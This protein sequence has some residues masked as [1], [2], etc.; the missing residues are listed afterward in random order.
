MP[1]KCCGGYHE[2][3]RFPLRETKGLFF[4]GPCWI[5]DSSVIL[6]LGSEH[7]VQEFK[8]IPFRNLREVVFRKPQPLQEDGMP[9][10]ALREIAL[11]KEGSGIPWYLA[12]YIISMVC[13]GGFRV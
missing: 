1:G 6:K 4:V 10:T 3:M 11:L 9:G 12:D 13:I 8:C 2:L 7:T 5:H